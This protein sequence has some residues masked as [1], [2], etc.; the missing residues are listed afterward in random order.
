LYPLAAWF[1]CSL[2]RIAA[3]SLRKNA[4][5]VPGII[6]AL[7]E[8]YAPIAQETGLDRTVKSSSIVKTLLAQSGNFEDD[9]LEC[10]LKICIDLI[11]SVSREMHDPECVMFNDIFKKYISE[12]VTAT[13]VLNQSTALALEAL[14]YKL[15]INMA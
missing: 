14:I 3:L 4:K 10:F 1:I 9:S 7:G 11:A 5:A 2:A 13:G 6:T 12:T 15:K 8:R